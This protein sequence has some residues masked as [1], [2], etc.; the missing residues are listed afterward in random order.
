[1]LIYNLD[2]VGRAIQDFLKKSVKHNEFFFFLYT[3]EF[4][5]D[6][7]ISSFISLLSFFFFKPM[8]L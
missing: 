2:V 1:M 3:V 6:D 8:S 5:A 7:A 4:P